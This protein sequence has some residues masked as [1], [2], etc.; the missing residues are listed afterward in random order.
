MYSTVL[1]RQ[2]L[3]RG[4]RLEVKLS[5]YPMPTINRC[6]QGTALTVHAFACY[7]ISFRE[8]FLL[9]IGLIGCKESRPLTDLTTSIFFSPLSLTQT[10][11]HRRLVRRSSIELYVQRATTPEGLLDCS[12]LLPPSLSLFLSYLAKYSIIHCPPT[13]LISTCILSFFCDN[14]T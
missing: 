9:F 3:L 10:K 4:D 5:N 11:L 7:Q 6:V 1:L 8:Y 12:F 14:V 13:P 2:E